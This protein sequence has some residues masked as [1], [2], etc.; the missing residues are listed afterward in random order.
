MRCKSVVTKLYLYDYVVAGQW[1]KRYTCCEERTGAEGCSINWGHVHDSNKYED[2]T[3]YMK[4]I[5]KPKPDYCGVYA[6]DCEMVR[7]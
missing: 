1:D 5:P 4:T 3:G 6:L 7:V 2:L